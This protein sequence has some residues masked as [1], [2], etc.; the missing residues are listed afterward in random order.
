MT[1]IL[2]LVGAL[3]ALAVAVERAAGGGGGVGLADTGSG[4][5][6]AG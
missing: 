6:G 4:V 5:D 2:I 3:I 1:R